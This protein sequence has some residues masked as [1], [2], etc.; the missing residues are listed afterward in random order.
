MPAFAC[1]SI[2]FPEL[3]KLLTFH[4]LAEELTS[5]THGPPW[6]HPKPSLG[7]K[8]K[9]GAGEG[10]KNGVPR[11]ELEQGKESRKGCH[12]KTCGRE[13]EKERGHTQSWC[14]GG[15]KEWVSHLDLRQ[16]RR[17]REGSHTDLVQRSPHCIASHCIALNW[18][19]IRMSDADSAL[20]HR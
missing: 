8:R 3:R 19:C 5:D 2:R 13:E 1:I 12:T 18:L 17:R 11:I 10:K 20:Y 7:V 16:R 9:A 14:R 6:G 4:K 15:K